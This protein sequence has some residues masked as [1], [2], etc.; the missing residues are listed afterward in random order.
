MFRRRAQEAKLAHGPVGNLPGQVNRH[1][2]G[3]AAGSGGVAGGSGAGAGVF[4]AG[5]GG[6]G[7]G[8]GVFGGSEALG[9]LGVVPAGVDA[10]VPHPAR[11]WNYWLGGRDYFAADQV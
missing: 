8:A 2:A 9:S 3:A 11:I 1:E 5:A 4:G 6:S 10:S 7:A